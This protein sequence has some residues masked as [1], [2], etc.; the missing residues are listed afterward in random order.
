MKKKEIIDRVFSSRLRPRIEQIEEN[1]L[2][3]SKKLEESFNF[4][5]N[6]KASVNYIK[7]EKGCIL[8]N[9]EISKSFLSA[10]TSSRSLINEINNENRGKSPLKCK[11]SLYLLVK[12]SDKNKS[13]SKGNTFTNSNSY[14]L[15]VKN[16]SNKNFDDTKVNN[17]IKQISKNEK[18][19]S[20][21]K[22]KKSIDIIKFLS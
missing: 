16:K 19:L 7:G 22:Y 12:S 2:I 18:G 15:M 9:S 10:S 13:A 11:T 4:I 6:M 20:N 8:M 5:E 1:Y 21:D 17:K 3:H 14:N